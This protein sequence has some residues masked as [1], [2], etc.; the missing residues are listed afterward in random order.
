MSRKVLIIL[1][2][3]TAAAFALAGCGGGAGAGAGVAKGDTG[4]LVDK[5]IID[6][7][8]DQSIAAKDTVEG[9]TD[10]FAYGMDASVFFGL[11]QADREKLSVYPVPSGSWSYLMNPI[12]NQAPYV[13]KTKTGKEYFNPLA[14]REVRYAINWLID[15]KKMVDEILL[16]GGEPAFTSMTPGQPGT[17]R[18]NIIATKLGMTERGDEKRAIA[19]IT[20]ALEAAAKLPENSGK[21]RKTGQFWTYK[22]E[23]IVVK[24]IIRVDDPQGRLPAG[25]YVADQLEKAGIKVERL[26]YDRSKAGRMVY[27]G[28]PAAYEWTM[29]TEGWGAGA[30]RRWWDVSI[31]QMYA[32]YYGYMPGGATEGFWNYKQDEIDKLAMKSYNG[33]FLT[34]EEYWND[35]LK[36][37]ELGLTEAVRIWVCSQIDYFIAN[38][39]RVTNRFVYGLGD[40][41]NGWSFITADVKPNDKGEKILRATQFSAKGGLFMSAWDPVGVDGFSDTYVSMIVEQ[42]TMREYFEAPN[43]AID[44]PYLVQWDL[45]DVQSNVGPDTTGDGKPEG[46]IDVPADAVKYD[47]ATKTWKKVGS[48]VKSYSTAK[49]TVKDSV[50]HDGNKIGL[51]DFVYSLGF[52]TDWSTKDGDADLAYE[53][54]YASQYQP[55]LETLKG[56][57]FN[58]DGS[59][60]TYYDFNWPMDKNRVAYGGLL[61]PKA[62]N[63]GRPTMVPWTITEAIG[64]LVTE[65][66]ASGTVYA[67]TEDP[68]MT[69]IDVASPA[70]V[71]DLKAKLNE[72]VEKKHVPVY[73]K[74]HMKPAEAVDAYKKTLAF[75]EKYGH[76]YV[77]N[78]PFYISKIDSTANYMELS[79]YRKGYP[80]KKDYWG[81]F[82]ALEVTQID[83]VAIPA[84]ARRDADA[85]IDLTVSQFTYPSDQTKPADK[86][87][88]VQVT[89][90]SQDGEK[91]YPAK[92]VKDGSFQAVIPAADLAKLQPGSYTLVSESKFADEAPSVKPGNL[93]LF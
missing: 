42:C 85:V 89:L 80:Y 90:I 40:G 69:Q 39:D 53:E 60:T 22:G 30:T 25:R 54:A 36:A 10:I 11:P 16:G 79:A 47:S 48:G 57:I 38:K 49:Y 15:R 83:N 3:V 2:I 31:S 46:L 6:V 72:M 45:K 29:Y 76:A 17:Y 70:C 51:A 62:G 21:L 1:A 14:I 44:T 78:G 43:T 64:L 82:F 19:E 32:P 24:F 91:A 33:W 71:A 74:D 63:P 77:S 7:R 87:A 13:W 88:K 73:V 52:Q 55:T 23:P 41:L 28:D 66:A 18:Y 61:S 67:I 68:S 81:K 75:I 5:I 8:M 93:V 92:Y 56:V 9:K 4:P 84:N 37:Q 12:P 50:W 20:A 26:E 35:N 27:G 65:G 59:F 86:D 58:K 34:D